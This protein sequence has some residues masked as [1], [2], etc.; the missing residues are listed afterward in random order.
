MSVGN[1]TNW[2]SIFEISIKRLCIGKL[3]TFPNVYIYIYIYIYMGLHIV[4]VM[5]K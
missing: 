2:L 3:I 1:S 4:V 5:S